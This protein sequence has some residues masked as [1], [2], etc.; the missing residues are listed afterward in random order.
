MTNKH[1]KFIIWKRIVTKYVNN[2]IYTEGEMIMGLFGKD[3]DRTW[4]NK[5]GKR[6][7]GYDSGKG[8]TDWYDSNGNLDSTSETPSDFEQDMNDEGY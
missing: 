6:F 7:Y 2:I 1:N 8:R 5:D 4:R 3:S